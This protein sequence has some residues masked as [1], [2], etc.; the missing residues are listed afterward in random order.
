M[1]RFIL[2][3]ALMMGVLYAQD[4][5]FFKIEPAKGYACKS[6]RFDTEFMYLEKMDGSSELRV[7]KSSVLKV[8]YSD[9]NTVWFDKSQMP[10]QIDTNRTEEYCML[11]G[12]AQLFS[13]RVKITVDFGEETSFWDGK[14][15]LKDK[16]GNVKDFNSLVDA[17]NYMNSLGWE[18]ISA[19]PMTSGQGSC[20]HYLMRRKIKKK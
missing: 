3:T 11:I 19:Y 10:K 1:K 9:G 18:F 6:L 13:S 7:E 16:S 2:L 17:L 4:T 15:Y 20:Y 8:R 5:V 14:E 12:T